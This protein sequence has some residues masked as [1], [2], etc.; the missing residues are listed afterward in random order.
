MNGKQNKNK[1]KG[2]IQLFIIL[3]KKQH[4]FRTMNEMPA[5]E[6]LP[7]QTTITDVTSATKLAEQR[8]ASCV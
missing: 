7:H 4:D 6:W 5:L 8:A 2:A 3:S 1:A